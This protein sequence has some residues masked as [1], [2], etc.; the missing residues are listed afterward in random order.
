MGF[1]LTLLY[2]VLAYLSPADL[3]PAL[4][5]YRIMVVVSFFGSLTAL[6]R[7]PIDRVRI[8]VPQTFLMVMLMGMMSFSRLVNGWYGGAVTSWYEFG[9]TA[10]VYFMVMIACHSMPRLRMLTTVWIVTSL[11]LI[12]QGIAAIYFGYRADLLVVTGHDQLGHLVER[13]RAVGWLGDPNDLA[14]QIVTIAPFVLLGWQKHHGIRNLILVICPLALICF[15]VYLTGSRG[16]L[17]GLIALVFFLLRDRV[18]PVFAGIM[19]GMAL[20]AMTAVSFGGGRALSLG[21]GSAAARLIVWGDGLTMFKQNPIFGIGYLR[22]THFSR[23]T[24]HNSFVL[25][26]SEL[27]LVGCF[28]WIGLLVF[29]IGQL[30]RVIHGPIKDEADVSMVRW[31]KAVRVGFSVFLVTGWFLSRTYIPTI[32]ILVAMSVVIFELYR[33]KHPELVE[34]ER[35]P[36]GKWL[37]TT[38]CV[39]VGATMLVWIMLRLRGI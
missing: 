7:I 23:Y 17:M 37:F 26:L 30:G 13:I 21:E 10:A 39:A 15:G 11:Y 19:S 31:A 16:G 18:K 9:P 20:F 14:Q 4:A 38:G 12:V 27:G 33:K 25:A 28:V 5:P 3:F 35:L 2:I 24:A 8:A 22:F 1:L 32:Y 6:P 36:V 34:L 29:S